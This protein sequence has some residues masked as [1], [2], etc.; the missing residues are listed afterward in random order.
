MAYDRFG[1]KNPNWG[2]KHSD[3]T[4]AKMRLAK[5][6]RKELLGYIISPEHQ[7]KMVAAKVA[8]GTQKGEKNGMWKGGITAWYQIIRTSSAYKEW[9]NKVYKRDNYRCVICDTPGSGKNLNADHIKPFAYYPELRFDVN[10]GR[11]L[12]IDC[13][14][15]T[16]TYAGKAKK[17]ELQTI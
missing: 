5:Q 10:N 3:A 9:R 11:T 16:D 13:H 7:V 17:Y 1:E 12:C 15:Q 6:R 14:K 2:K 8:L 4:R